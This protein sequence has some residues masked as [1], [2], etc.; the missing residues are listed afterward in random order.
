MVHI[1]PCDTFQHSVSQ[2][3]YVFAFVSVYVYECMVMLL[4]LLPSNVP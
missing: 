1:P 2:Q 3:P 4:S